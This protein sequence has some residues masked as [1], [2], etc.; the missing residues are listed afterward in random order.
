MGVRPCSRCGPS[1]W[2]AAATRT[3]PGR[4]VA[5]LAA[6]PQLA[7]EDIDAVLPALAGLPERGTE[8]ALLELLDR[9][10]WATPATL[11]RLAA[12]ESAGGRYVEA[13]AWLEKAA[14]R[15]VP[16]AALLIELARAAF[17][18]GDAK[19]AL[20]YLAH[21]RDLEPTNV[22]VH[23]LFGIVCVE[24]N[25]GAEAYESLARAVALAPDDPDI[26]YAMG[27]VSLHRHDPSEALPYFEA[28]VRLRPGDPRG[29]FALGAAK[30]HSQ[31]LEEAVTDLAAA[32]NDPRTAA[33]AHY[34]LARIA[35]QRQDL[36]TARREIDA[37]LR[38]NPVARRRLGRARADRDAAG[39]LRRRRGRAAEGARA[40]SRQL[41]GDAAPGGALRPHPRS[42]QGGAGSAAADAGCASRDSSPGVPAAR[43]GGAVTSAVC[44]AAVVLATCVVAA[45]SAAAGTQAPAKA[46]ARK[47]VAATAAEPAG[48]IVAATNA[49]AAGDLDRAATLAAGHLRKHPRSAAARVVVARVHLARGELD[50]AWRELNRAAAEHPRDVDVL[51]YLG[52]VSGQLAAEQFER[53]VQQ[54]PVSARGHQLLAE[55]FEAQERRSDAEREY[56]AALAIKPDL[57]EALLGLAR[58]Q[59]IRLDCDGAKALY[60]RAEAVRPTFD[61]AYGIGAC[62]LRE[63]EHDAARAQ[64]E[65]AV[66]RDPQSAVA[67]V[68]LGSALLGLNRAA[69]AITPL[70]RAVAIEPAMD[71]GWY[72]LGRAYQAA[73]RTDQAQR[74]FA[75]VERLRTE[76]PR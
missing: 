30:Y 12:I 35:R 22:A 9:R 53:L 40:R 5:A 33:G 50:A 43:A 72:V 6:H 13:R 21:A 58:L 26:N 73:G 42:P 51:Y 25:L 1:P 47:G 20:G 2:P 69:E 48:A 27:A 39:R 11:R 36:E 29:R 61:A 64:L 19:G 14:A 65:R 34:Y 49:L 57:L 3:A 59:R 41:R 62:L 44:L 68:G 66:A 31:R 70:E 60:A 45:S 54:S 56:Q 55:S 71:D 18:A 24:L 76:R 38:A 52:Q 37:A 17:K 16:D 46:P 8:Q 67:L 15:G 23:F 32:A 63:Q 75:T 74:A 4:T 28:Y 7:R 10:G